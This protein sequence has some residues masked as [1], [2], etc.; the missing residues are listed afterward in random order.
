MTLAPARSMSIQDRRELRPP[1][2]ERYLFETGRPKVVFV[3]VDDHD[4][5]SL[6]L[7]AVAEAVPQRQQRIE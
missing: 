5:R 6:R 4:T 2:G 3:D 1:K 7:V